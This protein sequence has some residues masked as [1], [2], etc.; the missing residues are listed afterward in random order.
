[1]KRPLTFLHSIFARARNDKRGAVAITV[2][3]SVTM[4][5]GFAAFVFDIGHVLYVQRSLQASADAAALAGAGEINCCASA[6]GTAVTVATQYS[7]ASGE[8]NANSAMPVTLVS[9]YPVEKC[10][11]SLGISCSGPDSANA[12]QVK[13]QAT[14][15]MWFAQ[16]LGVNSL[17]VTAVST[18]A[19]RAGQGQVL[20]LMV[21]LDTTASMNDADTACSVSGASRETCAKTG[22]LALL[23]G[24]NPSMDRVG[25][26]VFPPLASSTYA[27]DDYTCPSTNPK[28][29]SYA[30]SA[31]MTYDVLPLANT[32]KTSSKSTSLDASAPSVIAAGGGA[33]S[34]LAAVGGYGTYYGDVITAAQS[35]LATDGLSNSQK[36]IIFAS[37]GGANAKSSNMPSGKASNQCQEAI[38]A[39]KAAAAAGTWVYSIAYGSSTATG[40][41]STCTTDTSGPLAGLS[42][43]TTMQ[44]IASSPSKFYSDSSGGVTCPGALSISDMV[45]TFQD[46]SQSL[47]GPRL[48]PDNTT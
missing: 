34:G 17:T 1:M 5:F 36:V 28:I 47:Q 41:S 39:A 24:L 7:A 2:A 25:L 18:A 38:T 44:D 35:Y 37:D 9:G 43:C 29:A 12:I 16:L 10:L 14:V 4:I 32:Y 8:K 21:V 46:I 11:T 22:V 26:M 31:P 19:Y 48:I 6:P 13:E 15:P 3:L 42:S 45:A 40:V 20:D 23:N 30:A 27:T 33:C